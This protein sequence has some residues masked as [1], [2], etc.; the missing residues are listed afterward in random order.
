MTSFFTSAYILLVNPLILTDA[1]IPLSAGLIATILSSVSGCLFMGLFSKAPVIVVPGMGVNSFFSYT[2]VQSLGLSW[3][4]GLA[5]V[6]VSG[7]FFLL[8]SIT[9]LGNKLATGVPASLKQGITAGVGLL[10][11]FIGLQKGL[12]IQPSETLFVKLGDFSNPVTISTLLG[13]VITLFLF[14][15]NIKGSMLIGLF[16]TSLLTILLTGQVTPNVGKVQTHDYLLVFAKAEFSFLEF[17]FWIAVFSMT[18]I[19][20]FENMGLLNGLLTDSRKFPRAY[21]ALALS[22]FFSGVFGTSPTVAAAESSSGIAEGGKTGIPSLVTAVLFAASIFMLPVIGM[23]PG[24]A[25]APVLIIVG[26]LMMKSVQEIPF[27]DF[28]EGFPAFSIFACIPLTS[29]I[30]DGLAFGFIAYPLLKIAAGK[31]KQVP[32]VVYLIAGLFLINFITSAFVVH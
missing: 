17:P 24:N 32:N 11:T 30:A 10:L 3:K 1:G 15:R 28:S 26:A 25:V 16:A 22:T 18:M 14:V 8:A 6:M 21:Q 19:V 7:L 23:I 13:L 31:W 27:H 20:M 5:V 12:I 4:Q 2:I 9:S 29:S